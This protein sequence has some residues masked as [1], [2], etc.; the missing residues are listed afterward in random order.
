MLIIGPPRQNQLENLPRA[1]PEPHRSQ[2]NRLQH[3]RLSWHQQP[4]PNLIIWSCCAIQ[5]V[6]MIILVVMGSFPMR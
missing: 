4:T 3:A 2:V 6:K 1:P 5:A